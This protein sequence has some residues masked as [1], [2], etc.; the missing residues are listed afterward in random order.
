MR[1]ALVIALLP[2][3]VGTPVRG[4]AAPQLDG[5]SDAP[6][7]VEPSVQAP[8]HQH[9]RA[10]SAFPRAVHAP[11][12]DLFPVA[13]LSPIFTSGPL[14]EA[15]AAFD[16]GQDAKAVAAFDAAAQLGPLPSGARFL[17]ATALVRLGQKKEGVAEFV[18]IAALDPALASRCHAAAAAAFED[19]GDLA[20]AAAQYAAVAASSPVHRDAVLGRA[21]VL[22]KAGQLEA[23]RAVLEPLTNAAAPPGGSGRDFGAEALWERAALETRL[24]HAHKAKEDYRRIVLAHPLSPLADDARAKSEGLPEPS[25]EDLLARAEIFLNANRNQLALAELDPLAK[26]HPLAGDTRDTRGSRDGPGHKVELVCQVHFDRGKALRKMR[27]HSE[28]VASLQDV[29]GRCIAPSEESLRARALYLLGQSEAVTD[30]LRAEKVYVTLAQEYP[31]HTF[32]DDALYFAADLALKDPGGRARAQALLQQL[33]ASYPNGD[34]A[35]E[36]LFRLFWIARADGDGRA[37]IPYLAALEV[38]GSSASASEGRLRAAEP[39]LRARYWQAV[40]LEDRSGLRNLA[41]DEPWSYYGHLAFGALAEAERPKPSAAASVD[42]ASLSLRAGPLLDDPN[43]L[44]AVE[45]LQMGVPSAAAEELERIDRA[46]LG[47]AHGGEPLLLLAMA[48]DAAEDSRTAHAIAKTMLEGGSGSDAASL[49]P[50]LQRVIWQVAY[51]NAYRDLIEHWAKVYGV[52]PD[53]MQA[54]MREESALDPLVLSAA[55]AVGLTQLMPATAERLA[56]KLGLG[57]VS[58]SS[59]QT[60]ELNVRLGTAYLGELLARYKGREVLAVAAYNAGEGAVD[61]WMHQHD[62]EPMDAFVEDIPVAET[63][64]YVKRVLTS[65]ATYRALYG[66]AAPVARR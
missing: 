26:R 57:P 45:L 30:P 10:D 3:M 39:T 18:Q 58:L 41:E 24:G 40:A 23:A 22:A 25:A 19:L 5:G 66:G 64:N 31:K 63:R 47:G 44:T 42:T 8:A 15:K 37:G 29:A 6:G 56:H 51:P 27:R 2:L 65:E 20:G 62:G 36:A 54:L 52:P 9:V 17:R 53:L 12:A 59:L 7:S 14:A 4:A 1:R 49:S 28:A 38:A 16:A 43:F 21:R 11:P 34:Y 13:R 60:A 61:R 33:L 46:G 48:M 32:A 55:G 35:P 50:T